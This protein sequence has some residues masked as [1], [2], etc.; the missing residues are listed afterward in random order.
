[1][2]SSNGINWMPRLASEQNEWKSITWSPDLLMFMAVASTGTN[3]SMFSRD[4]ITWTSLATPRQNQWT[5]VIWSAENNSFVSVARSGIQR[6]MESVQKSSLGSTNPRS[7]FV[8][9]STDALQLPGGTEGQRPE[10]IYPGMI[11]YNST[12]NRMEY[13]GSR[14]TGIADDNAAILPIGP[15]SL[16]PALPQTGSIRFNTQ[17]RVLEFFTGFGG[18]GGLG[19]QR[20]LVSGSAV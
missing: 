9:P 2:T 13:Y 6:I 7:G 18:F 3:R 15:T 14:W 12:R 4:G 20:I 17:T 5:S 1:M 10:N 11:R 16:R 19:W 8:L